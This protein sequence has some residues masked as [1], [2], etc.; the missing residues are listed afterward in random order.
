MIISKR[1]VLCNQFDS[2]VKDTSTF[3]YTNATNLSIHKAF[4]H[5]FYGS[6][7]TKLKQFQIPTELMPFPYKITLL[8]VLGI[9]FPLVMV[10]QQQLSI[11]AIKA[12]PNYYWGEATASD[13]RQAQ[14]LALEMLSQKI[15]VTVVSSFESTTLEK[16]G[17]NLN[18]FVEMNN[19][20]VK[21][22]TNQT[23]ND[24]MYLYKPPKSGQRHAFAYISKASLN[25]LFKDREE[26][27]FN[28]FKKA[29]NE[30]SA[31][32]F[33]YALKHYYY[34]LILKNSLPQGQNLKA[35]G[36]LLDV[37]IPNRINKLLDSIEIKVVAERLISDKEKEIDLILLAKNKPIRQLDFSFWTGTKEIFHEAKDGKATITLYGSGVNLSDL[38]CTPYYAYSENLYEINGLDQVWSASPNKPT[39][40][41]TIKN[42]LGQKLSKTEAL[43]PSQMVVL[44]LSEGLELDET[45]EKQLESKVSLFKA[46][47][48]DDEVD[49]FFSEKWSEI[50]KYN[51]VSFSRK[52]EKALIYPTWN[53]LEVREIP[54]T[55]VYQSLGLQTTEYLITDA[56][57]D[58]DLYDV[59]YGILKGL[60][61][62]I[63]EQS[64]WGE[65]WKQ[66]HVLIKF[67]EKYRTAF[68]TRDIETIN[69]IFADDARIII[70]RKLRAGESS[71]NNYS[72]KPEG[73]NQPDYRYVELKKQQYLENLKGLFKRTQDIYTGYTTFQIVAKNNQEG[74]YGVSMR[75][76]YTSTGY[77]DEGYLFLL[78]D[79]NHSEPQIMVRAWQPQEWRDNALIELS[80]FKVYK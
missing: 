78:I 6:V 38:N 31:L 41:R 16:R 13:A 46:G 62:D 60:Y 19:G 67:L 53:Q 30:A 59:N 35:D 48:L 3:K 5:C 73:K 27:V 43:N 25:K 61:K 76:N 26:T 68:L 10:A 69:Q 4:M 74:V 52:Q 79:F 55:N 77:A 45:I 36:E 24:V 49:L 75:Q 21:S 66:R 70:G 71:G 18:Q 57:K 15:Q 12:N 17:T 40:G 2:T 63:Q 72:Y 9:A 65:D 44:S 11:E 29:E 1:S 47:T 56:T 42:Q 80:D 37:E 33:S 39:F 54:V 8:L 64:V 51:K 14:D 20:Y 34:A 7:T 23:L 50:Q 32:N 22:Y 58:G 28:L